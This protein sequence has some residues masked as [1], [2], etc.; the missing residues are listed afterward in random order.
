M[1]TMLFL[2]EDQKTEKLCLSRSWTIGLLEEAEKQ[3]CCLL[4]RQ[5][6]LPPKDK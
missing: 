1:K 6:F 4:T 3:T 2:R 5:Y